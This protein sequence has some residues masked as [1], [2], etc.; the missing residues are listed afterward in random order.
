MTFQPPRKPSFYARFSRGNGG[1]WVMLAAVL[2]VWPLQA[3]DGGSRT[4][5]LANREVARREAM[6]QQANTLI[7]QGQVAEAKGDFV[8]AMKDY[9]AA[10]DMLPE[11]PMTASLR[12]AARDGYSRAT[13]AQA[14]K[15]AGEG[16]YSESKQLLGTVLA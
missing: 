12:A 5:G 11:S 9:K 7:A 2:G 4:A 10:Y 1:L 16:R 14:R 8:E 15:L 3:G 13:V 6:M